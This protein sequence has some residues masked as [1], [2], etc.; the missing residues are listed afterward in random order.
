MLGSQGQTP[1]PE[2]NSTNGTV[3]V[4]KARA[5]CTL[6]DNPNCQAMQDKFLQM[7][8]GIVA[9]KERLEESLAELQRTCQLAR[10]NLEA[11]IKGLETQQLEEETNLAEGTKNLNTAQE[12][13]RLKSIQ[14]H[15]QTVEMAETMERCRTNINNFKSEMCALRK[16]RGE[17][18]KMKGQDM[19]VIDCE[20]STW[21]E[22]DC[23]AT[24]DGGV[25]VLKRSIIVHP[26]LG[27]ACPPLQMQR[28]C[29]ENACPVDCSL[30]A[31]S[32]WSSCSA[33]C[34]GGVRQRDRAVRQQAQNG[35]EPCGESSE[36]EVCNG[37]ACDAD[38]ELSE[39]GRW[40]RCSKRCDGGV[41]ERVRTVT[42]RAIGTGTCPSE[43]SSERKQSMEC[44]NRACHARA[45]YPT[46][47]CEAKLDVVLVLDGSGSLGQSGWDATK[48]AASMIAAAMHGGEGKIRLA[49]LLFSGPRTWGQYDLCTGAAS[50]TPDLWSDCGIRWI[51]HFTED[52]GSVFAGIQGAEWPRASTLTSGALATVESELSRGRSDANTV[53]IVITDGRPL[54]E[55]RTRQAARSFM[56]YVSHL[57]Y[58]IVGFGL[59]RIPPSFPS[60]HLVILLSISPSECKYNFIFQSDLKKQLLKN[61]FQQSQTLIEH[62]MKN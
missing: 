44:N 27:Q 16:I 15:E 57:V 53:V 8:T 1:E 45:G 58:R 31:W 47:E 36:E 7:Q 13:S 33:A 22:E 46:L 52:M 38:C 39:W 6:R 32:G 30:E 61:M 20:V 55:R 60:F 5:K 21:T 4:R 51:S 12:Q 17:L 23:S 59:Y 40:G 28:V 25:Q 56:S 9:L 11:Q 10:E 54:N 2:D 3:S 14:H 49:A 43:H 18:Y 19:F 41:Q 62:F 35:G 50:G 48:M 37:Q 42:K 34:G 29:N 26:N 24:C